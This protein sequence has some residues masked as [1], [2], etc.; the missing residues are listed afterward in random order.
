M[1]VGYA[2]FPRLWPHRALAQNRRFENTYLLFWVNA[3]DR[4]WL[5]TNQLT[6]SDLIGHLNDCVCDIHINI[7]NLLF[8]GSRELQWGKIH[9]IHHVYYLHY[10]AGLRSNLF[11][12]R[13]LIW[14]NHESIHKVVHIQDRMVWI[15]TK[16]FN[17]CEKIQECWV[18]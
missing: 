11:W 15:Q 10:M 2:V 7:L 13:K 14:G 5:T 1:S 18:R 12:N 9:W 4:F 3:H 6:I 16:Y 8:T 17:H